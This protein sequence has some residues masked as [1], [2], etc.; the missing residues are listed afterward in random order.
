MQARLHVADEE[1]A[2][3]LHSLAHLMARVQRATAHA[4]KQEDRHL[5]T[6]RTH[7][8]DVSP[9]SAFHLLA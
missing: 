5:Q 8:S 6:L 9:I 7:E 4:P 3:G 2:A 1:P